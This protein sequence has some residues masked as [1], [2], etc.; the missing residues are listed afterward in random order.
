M[1]KLISMKGFIILMCSL[2]F[3][4]TN[5]QAQ[6]WRKISKTAK[7][8]Y[9]AANYSKAAEYYEL[10]WQSKTSKKEFLFKAA[11]CY[12]IIKNYPK[13]AEIFQQLRKNKDELPLVDWHYGR[14]LKNQEKYQEA[15]DIFSEFQQN[16]EGKDRVRILQLAANDIE[17]C[18]MALRFKEENL[19][20]QVV[21]ENPG[22]NVN[23]IANEFAPIPFS[24]DILYF[25][26]DMKGNKARIYRSQRIG[27]EWIQAVE[28]KFPNTPEGHLGNGTFTPDGKRFYFTI[29]KSDK[30]WD[31]IQAQCEIYVT[32]RSENKWTDPVKLRDYIRMDG[33]TATHPFVTHINGTEILYYVTDRLGGKG[34]LD[35]WYTTRE[36]SSDDYDFTLPQ[37]AG[38]SINTP[39]DEITPYY[40]VDESILYFSSNGHPSI[41]GFDIFKSSGSGE[42][43]KQAENIGLPF[44]SSADD[45]FYKKNPTGTGGFFVSNRMFELEKIE[46]TQEDIFTFSS[47]MNIPIVKG[48]VI[49]KDKGR[50]LNKV[51]I[52]LFELK[53]TGQKRLLT[54]QVSDDGNFELGLLPN[55]KYRIITSK[56]GFGPESIEFDTY[57]Y[58]G[59]NAYNYALAM[60]EGNSALAKSETPVFKNQG[61][62]NYSVRKAEKYTRS[63][64]APDSRNATSSSNTY[65]PERNTSTTISTK[66]KE[67]IVSTPPVVAPTPQ[68][69]G[70]YWKIQFTVV[71]NFRANDSLFDSARSYGRLDT[72]FLEN[73]GWTRVLIAEFFDRNE[74]LKTAKELQDRGYPD[75]FIVK[76]RNG[77][78]LSK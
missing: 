71:A 15:I 66:K 28:P 25:S 3:C 75:A 6:D 31:G 45:N 4:F 34:G 42:Q 47:P 74:A 36:I 70:T 55:R 67:P 46:T 56:A 77:V 73:K 78:R 23:T 61:S 51:R 5:L 14:I 1:L 39:G 72:E 7:K 53:G 49:N 19:K 57:G 8:H 20:A 21:L 44:N 38:P 76:Y 2:F 43:F 60:S 29:C 13:A 11:E 33:K 16:Y 10:A 69:N 62:N 9:A 59:T 18:E 12:A 40:N 41:G 35:I 48:N 26:S 37:N 24:D 50:A 64:K 17:G 68:F 58:D 27:G 54:S 22:E 63:A 52:A 30:I 32:K 65:T